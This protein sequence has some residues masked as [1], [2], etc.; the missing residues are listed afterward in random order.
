MSLN[1]VTEH[2][3]K[4][5]VP[6]AAWRESRRMKLLKKGGLFVPLSSDVAITRA[7]SLDDLRSAYRLV[8]DAFVAKG[9]IHPSD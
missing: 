8:H 7:T 5:A 9:F 3:G 6:S 2:A 1:D 4:A